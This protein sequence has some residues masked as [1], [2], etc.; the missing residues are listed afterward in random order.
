MS[1]YQAE[2][3]ES[4]QKVTLVNTNPQHPATNSGNR[5]QHSSSSPKFLHL[6]IDNDRRKSTKKDEIDDDSSPE[7]LSYVA[8]NFGDDFD[9][10]PL[11][12]NDNNGKFALFNAFKQLSVNN[13]FCARLPILEYSAADESKNVR[14]FQCITLPDGKVREIDMKVRELRLIN[15]INY[16]FKLKGN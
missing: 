1:Q 11:Q 6:N 5:I 9:D 12:M 15:L 4:L 7:E 14:N 13:D 10:E 16:I 3:C 8:G 2:V